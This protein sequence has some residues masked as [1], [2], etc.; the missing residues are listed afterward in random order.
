MC[1]EQHLLLCF[2]DRWR[3]DEQKCCALERNHRKSRIT[4]TQK[5]GFKREFNQPLSIKIS[6]IYTQ[7]KAAVSWSAPAS[8]PLYCLVSAAFH[9][10]EK[11]SSSP[12]TEALMASARRRL[13]CRCEKVLIALLCLFFQTDSSY[14][15][16]KMDVWG[17][18]S[19]RRFHPSSRW[20]WYQKTSV[21]LI[22][23][24]R[25]LFVA[26]A[27]NKTLRAGFRLNK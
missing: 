10:T 14:W 18:L 27:A 13:P 22:T 3:A 24:G 16:G 1:P 5:L 19:E 9:K 20:V 25:R 4:P 21:S 26:V 8:P 2:R 6:E 17:V 15:V 7:V 11:N 12:D 23:S